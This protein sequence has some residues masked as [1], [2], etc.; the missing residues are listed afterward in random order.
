MRRFVTQLPL[1]AVLLL[2]ACYDHNGGPTGTSGVQLQAPASLTSTSLDSAVYLQWTDN[3]FTS[4]PSDFAYYHVY[5]TTYDLD[6][7]LCGATWVTEGTTA[8][9]QFLVGA[10][11][12][13]VPQC[14]E[15]TAV[16]LDGI[17]SDPS[18][19]RNDT[20]RPDGLNVLLYTTDT[21]AGTVSGFTFASG[22]NLA[23]VGSAGSGTNDFTVTH[24]SSGTYL[25][26]QR[27][28]VTMT[29]YGNQPIAALT[30]IDVAPANGYSATGFQA[31][32]RWG[33]VFQIDNGGAFY[34]YG[35]L[36]VSAVGPNYV[37]FDW[38]YQTDPGNPELIRVAS[39]K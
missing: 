16:S 6:Q 7:N 27:S 29:P 32:P 4:D 15:V 24:D 37:I 17:E 33:Y 20:P 3:A 12:N 2:G 25:V 31:L 5:S 26:P 18:P 34:Q 28:G 11:A 38:S 9:F 35:A 21:L 1:A 36:R 14:Y 13:G 39:K 10:L 19:L 23:V 8:S 22:G 30:S